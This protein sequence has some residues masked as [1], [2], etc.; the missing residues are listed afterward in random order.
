MSIDVDFDSYWEEEA[1]NPNR[2]RIRIGR[3]YQAQIPPVTLDDD[4][5]LNDLETLTWSPHS[6][7]SNL[8]LDQYFSI[9]KAIELFAQ[10]VDTCHEGL[11]DDEDDVDDETDGPLLDGRK[12]RP[13]EIRQLGPSTHSEESSSNEHSILYKGSSSAT[14]SAAAAAASASVATTTTTATTSVTSLSGIGIT[15]PEKQ[16]ITTRQQRLQQ[17]REQQNSLDNN[18]MFMSATDSSPTATPLKHTT[19]TRIQNT[20]KG[21]STFVSLHHDGHKDKSCLL[22]KLIGG[23][24]SSN[25][26]NTGTNELSPNSPINLGKSEQYNLRTLTQLLFGRWTTT[27][28][29]TFAKALQVCGKNFGAIKKDYFPWKSVRSIIEFYYCNVDKENEQQQSQSH[30]KNN[31][32][33]QNNNNRSPN[34]K[35]PKDHNHH[36]NQH[37]RQKS[38]LDDKRNSK[39]AT[40]DDQPSNNSSTTNTS[41][42][43]NSTNTAAAPSSAATTNANSSTKSSEEN[44]NNNENGNELT[45][46][47]GSSTT[48]D[49]S[50]VKQKS[51]LQQ[52]H[53]DDHLVNPKNGDM[54]GTTNSDSNRRYHLTGQEV[55]PLKAKPIPFQSGEAFAGLD[56]STIAATNSML[57]S[58]NLYLHGELILKLNAQQQET[59]QKWVES[60]ESVPSSVTSSTGKSKKRSIGA[61]LSNGL[62]N[63]NRNPKRP[64]M[65]GKIFDFDDHLSAC[66]G[67]VS[68]S[69]DDSMTSNESSSLVASS[70]SSSSTITNSAAKKARVKLENFSTS[71]GAATG[72]SS[73]SPPNS[74]RKTSDSVQSNSSNGS[75]KHS[76]RT[77]SPSV[78]NDLLNNGELD[79]KKILEANL[80]LFQRLEPGAAAVAA[81]AAL[82]LLFNGSCTE[83][84]KAHSN[85]P[86]PLLSP[87]GKSATKMDQMGNG[88]QSP[89]PPAALSPIVDRVSTN[90]FGPVD[91]TSRKSGQSSST[92][93]HNHQQHHHSPSNSSSPTSS[94]MGRHRTTS[95]S[96]ISSFTNRYIKMAQENSGRHQQ[97]PSL[98]NSLGI[99]S[100]PA[101]PPPI[102]SSI[103]PNGGN[104]SGTDKHHVKK[105][106]VRQ[107]AK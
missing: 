71:N 98:A 60:M 102:P 16:S 96:P 35:Y 33:S 87:V 14:A 107:F 90:G 50:N 94:S 83:P 44:D 59:G 24:N 81:A 40:R 77:M 89:A 70:P 42:N 104:P 41:S 17:Q 105:S 53:D 56:P 6:M 7:L 73:I 97:H 57:G 95:H 51:T 47:D 5:D 99:F 21:L 106:L 69:D 18:N 30:N 62:T 84:P 65:D 27:E 61:G 23:S 93:G 46:A 88:H 3:Q 67:D 15:T 103:S 31:K 64:T 2:N 48:E 12:E 91:L 10:A 92:N 78:S 58:L 4:H 74:G 72:S 55:R 8:E 43:T 39:R 85:Y 26:A 66:G 32:K 45:K 100:L 52:S 63:S 34:N 68:G 29:E 25:T 54:N 19:N 86:T 38:P 1:R 80:S 37:H 36:S 76:T 28:A 9:A 22:S 20:L 13:F 82:P 49:D 75:G 101:V 79:L 11:E